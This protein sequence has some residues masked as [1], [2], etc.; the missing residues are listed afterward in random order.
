MR[1]SLNFIV[2]L[3]LSLLILVVVGIVVSSLTKSFFGEAGSIGQLG[4]WPMDNCKGSLSL[5]SSGRGNCM[6]KA[7]ILASNCFGKKYQIREDNCQGSVRCE[8]TVS[9]DYFQATCGWFAMTG[10]HKYAL[11]IGNKERDS[12]PVTCK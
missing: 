10:T 9:Y 1:H 3:I 7:Q 2:E 12:A 5:S 11:C 4:L 6:I 8:D